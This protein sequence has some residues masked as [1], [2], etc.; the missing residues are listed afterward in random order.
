VRR[1]TKQLPLTYVLPVRWREDQGIAE[2]A[3]YLESIR[4]HLDE[5]IVVDGSESAVFD[6]HATMLGDHCR[7]TRPG[8][9]GFLNGKVAGVTTGIEQAS[10]EFVVIADDDVRHDAQS[11][12]ALVDL[13]EDHELVRPQNYFDPLPWHA[14]WD[15]ARSLLNRVVSG[16]PGCRRG[17]FPGTFG[18]R[19]D[20]FLG[21]GAYDGDVLFE[22][23]ELIRTVRVARGRTATP[24]GLYVRRR[25]PT[26]RHFFSQRIRQ[27]YD[28]FAL[29]LRMAFF[30]ALGPV[31]AALLLGGRWLGLALIAGV[32]IGTAEAGRRTAG[33]TRVFPLSG[34]LL[35]PGWAMERAV[36]VWLALGERILFGGVRYG[37]AVISRAANSEG[38]IAAMCRRRR[39]TGQRPD[40]SDPLASKPIS[41]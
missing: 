41:L 40:S 26:T 7:H 4:P 39:R 8:G 1:R 9:S 27:A 3:S 23:L 28:D 32:L 13:L 33:G 19:R 20:F 22:N 12:S 38:Q 24:L 6:W 36:T 10:N 17:D 15:T 14:R 37:S 29:P 34:S 11:L 16:D 18:I 5:V 35:A 30:F 31:V 2:L 25:P 21:M